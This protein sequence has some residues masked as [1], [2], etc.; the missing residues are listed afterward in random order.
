VGLSEQVEYVS[1]ALLSNQL[2][3]S[4]HGHFQSEVVSVN[5]VSIALGPRG[6]R[7]CKREMTNIYRGWNSMSRV[8]R[9]ATVLVCCL[10]FY[11]CGDD[12]SPADQC[13]DGVSGA[14]EA[15]DDGNQ[16]DGDGCRNDC[17]LPR[18]GDGVVQAGAEACDDGN[19]VD[20]DA[21]RN[22]C[23][24][25]SCGDGVV[26]AGEACDDGNQVD[27][28]GCRNMCLAATC[29]DGVVQAGV[30]ACDDGNQIDSDACRT[31]CLVAICG[32]GVVQADVEACDDG[33][34]DDTDGCRNTC[35]VAS[36]GDGVVQAGVEACDDGNT[37]DTDACR[38]TCVVAV[39]GDGAVQVGVEFCD[40]GNTN[41]T[42][43]C[44][45]TCVV[46]TCGDSVVQVGV[47]ACD[48]GNTDDTDAC[49]NTCVI[50]FCGDAAVQAGVEACDDGNTSN[51][52]ACLNSCRIAQCGD[53]IIQAGVEACDDGNLLND[54]GCSS[55]CTVEI[56]GD[57]LVQFSRGETCDDGNLVANDGCDASC[58]LEPFT[59]TAPVLI[60]GALACT[61]A[62]ANAARKVAV[63]TSGT[64]FAVLQCGTTAHAVSS[65]DRGR[66]FSAPTNLSDALPNGPVTIS[67]VAVGTGPTGTAYAALMVSTGQVYLRITN[68]RGATWGAPTLVGTATS[69]GSGL[70]LESFND[71]L[72]I[73]FS[74]SGGV[75]VAINHTRGVGAFVITPVAMS[76]A[77][78]DLVFDIRLGTLAVVAD[79]PG[80]HIRESTDQG[81]T[82]GTEVNP[83]GEQYYS[84]WAIGNGSIFAVG[85]NLG[86]SGN[87]TLLYKIPTNNLSTSTSIAGLPAVST[88]QTRT[89]AADSS[90]NAYVASQLNAGGVQL[91]KLPAGTTTFATARSLSATGTSP[92]ASAL[93]GGAGVAVVFTKGTEVYATIQAY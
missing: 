28:D 86:A 89:V 75:A 73:G 23:V 44:R 16:I 92:I 45:N 24:A 62:T 53:A 84:D 87:A 18:C 59:T 1:V 83:P 61:T 93:P 72:Y 9:S 55:R 81:T 33:N 19:Q 7:L 13:G 46:A 20:T 32:D 52:D 6:V 35:T 12:P 14:T 54:D 79:T 60:S 42:D 15:C 2:I 25:A 37:D 82:F 17:S 5:L 90:G 70:S 68:D 27:T 50:A 69:T 40:D 22:T 71:D 91:D 88:A 39:C 76:I 47:E 48:D 64:L 4:Q 85:T 57:G 56:C 26:Q 58:K 49:R 29:G 11:S 8:F 41:E 10:V 30:E 43:A 80:F 3:L 78:F 77:F 67:Q 74:T 66:T 36:C 21:C 34:Q 65:I 38:N 31:S 51:T 63:D